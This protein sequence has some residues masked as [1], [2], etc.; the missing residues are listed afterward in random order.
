MSVSAN[1][2]GRV[3]QLRSVPFNSPKLPWHLRRCCGACPHF[4]GGKIQMV[5]D[6]AKLGLRRD[7]RSAGC[8]Y[9]SRKAAG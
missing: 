7:G 8:E 5:A 9:W 3:P 4:E 1:L 6:C 2:N